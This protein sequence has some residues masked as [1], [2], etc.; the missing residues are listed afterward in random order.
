MND[1][2]EENCV[3]NDCKSTIICDMNLIVVCEIIMKLQ[4][5]K[6]MNQPRA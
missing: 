5:A 4:P 3:D 6:K 2:L 1:Y